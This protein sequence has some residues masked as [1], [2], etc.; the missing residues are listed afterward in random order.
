MSALSRKHPAIAWLQLNLFSSW[1]NVALSL[2]AVVLLWHIVPALV[3]WALIDATW[4]GT[5][6]DACKVVN[7]NGDKVDAPGACWTFVKI[8]WPQFLFGLWYTR[9]FDQAWR[10]VLAFAI[11]V[12]VIAS[13]VGPWLAQKTRWRVA[14]GALVIYP[15]VAFALLHGAWLG[16]P[17]AQTSDWG[18]LTLTLALAATGI[19]ISLP[20]GIVLALGRRSTLPV[21]KGFCVLWIEF[22]RGMP[23]ITLLFIAS[24]ML[25]FFLP[26]GTEIDK[27]F[28]A[29]IVITLFASAYAAEAIRGGIASVARGQ[30][31]AAAALGLGYWRS[32]IFITLPQALKVAIPALVNS[33]IQLFKDTSLVL[34]IGL[35]ELLNIVQVAARSSEWK[36]YDAEAY[37]FAATIFFCFC[38]GMARFS[39]NLEASLDKTDAARRVRQA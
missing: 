14:L 30:Y 38:Y 32:N 7:A 6:S 22:L 13:L 24:V 35:L 15:F 16:L 3:N 31:E 4:S 28:R 1:L 23:L 10:P 19:I 2:V 33:C 8:R 18:G 34:I 17:V 12:V 9:N 27:V 5:T 25:P 29:M 26:V 37:V 39:Q 21:I 20:I 36:G 11:A